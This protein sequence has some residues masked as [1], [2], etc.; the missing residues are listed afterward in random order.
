M[1]SYKNFKNQSKRDAEG[2]DIFKKPNSTIKEIDMSKLRRDKLI[3][4]ISFYRRN[5]HRFIDHYFGIKLHPYQV[6]LVYLMSISDS[7]VA[8]CSRAVGKTWLVGVFACAK[9][10]LYPNSEI[11]VVSSTKQQAGIIV[12]DKITSLRNDYPNLAR[13]IKKLTENMNKWQVDFYNGSV[14]KIVASRDSSRGKR[15]TFTIYE[16][17]RLIDKQV[18]DAVIRPFAYI[19]QAP[20]LKNPKYAHLGEEPKEVFISSAYR[21]YLWWFDETKKNIIAMLKGD[22]AG[23]VA[24]DFSVAIRHHI[25]TARQIRNEISKM[26]EITAQEEIFNI[27]YGENS[28]A[29]FKLEMFD[30]ARTIQKAFYPQRME[31]YN[32]KKNPYAIKKSEGE[33]RLISCDV[34]QKAGKSND[35]SA[36]GCLRLMP[37]RRGYT[38]DLAYME[39]FSGVD[40]IS[41]SA[42]IKQLYYAFDA[43]ILVL[44]VGTGGGGLPMYDQLGQI[45]TDSESG[46]EWPAWTIVPDI[47]ISNEN[48]EELSKRTLG[49]GAVPNIY[50]ISA[51]AK[52]NSIMAV[53]MRDKLQKRMFGFLVDEMSAEDYL[54]KSSYQKEYLDQNDP[55]AKS[56]FLAPYVQTSLLINECINLSMTVSI[57]NIK[58]TE[59]PGSRKDR[60]SSLLYG[61]YYASILDQELLKE[62][63][64][65][66]SEEMMS[67]VQS[68]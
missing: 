3:D 14:I 56:W 54:I 51:S 38:I 40:S 17:F 4:W 34:A 50:P 67:L 6:L 2:Q 65:D 37:T 12:S 42:R 33:I 61:T 16:E 31:T 29:Y 19:R 64:Y 48:Y 46:V 60:F 57:G 58:L 52:L 26:D 13:E 36:T 30:R 27:P 18:L 44:D 9:A 10:V 32:F 39:T 22:N 45:T 21:K 1:P 62:D 63:N 15:S 8:I 28:D 5:M 25:K 41:Q 47:T 59:V 24:I 11:V 20:Y 49:V 53:Q 68:V 7:F 35:L 55:T 66:P 23:F 43:D